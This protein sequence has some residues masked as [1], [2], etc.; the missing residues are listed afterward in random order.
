VCTA[1]DGRLR[2]VQAYIN[3]SA[4]GA[5]ASNTRHAG[6]SL[7]TNRLSSERGDWSIRRAATAAAAAISYAS[8]LHRS[9]RMARCRD[10]SV[11]WRGGGSQCHAYLLSPSAANRNKSMHAMPT[12]AQSS[13]T[14]RTKPGGEQVNITTG[15]GGVDAPGLHSTRHCIALDKEHAS[16]RHY[17]ESKGHTSSW[18]DVTVGRYVYFLQSRDSKGIQALTNTWAH[19]L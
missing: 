18:E 7:N 4:E 14:R 2:R 1:T 15:A 16:T 17:Q 3:I 12:P 13:I 8:L 5:A 19:G 10:T 6:G 11:R 9:S